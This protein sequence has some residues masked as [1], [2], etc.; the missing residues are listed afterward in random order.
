MSWKRMSRWMSE[1]NERAWILS[2][3][4]SGSERSEELLVLSAI[5][6]IINVR[7]NHVRF[8]SQTHQGKITSWRMS[9]ME[10][11]WSDFIWISSEKG[12]WDGLISFLLLLGDVD[13][14]FY[15]T[16]W[17]SFA[18]SPKENYI[19]VFFSQFSQPKMVPRTGDCSFDSTS[20]NLEVLIKFFSLRVSWK[21]RWKFAS[22]Q[23]FV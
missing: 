12:E 1:A 6:Y 17:I 19:F 5:S 16:S 7:L 8:F 4:I 21:L 22:G 23:V 2:D 14:S 15:N 20:Q 11:S 10:W 18:H 13:C 3:N 9:E